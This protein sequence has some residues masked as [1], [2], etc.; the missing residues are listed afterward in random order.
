[1]CSLSRCIGCSQPDHGLGGLAIVKGFGLW[2][3]YNDYFIYYQYNQRKRILL[4][5]YVDYII[6]T[7]DN[8]YQ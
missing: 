6:I 3:C 4:I 7:G 5:V 2:R 8:K 1:M